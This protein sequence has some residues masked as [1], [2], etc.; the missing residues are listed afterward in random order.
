MTVAG[1]TKVMETIVDIRIAAVA[2]GERV[3][4]YRTLDGAR[5]AAAHL[6]EH[7]DDP[8]AITVRPRGLEALDDRNELRADRFDLLF[9]GPP[10]EVRHRLARWWDP[11]APPARPF[12][13]ELQRRR[14]SAVRSALTPR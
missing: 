7:G 2:P 14:R 10:D 8:A 12:E 9:D 3:A 6:V 11:A 1:E 5:R 13:H 4:T